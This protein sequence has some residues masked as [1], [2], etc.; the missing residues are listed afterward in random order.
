[1]P[2]PEPGAMLNVQSY[3]GVPG[4]LQAVLPAKNVAAV[5]WWMPVMN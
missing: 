5:E 2:T 1:M 3:A 4:L